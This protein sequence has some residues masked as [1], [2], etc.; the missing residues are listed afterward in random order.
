[1]D[2]KSKTDDQLYSFDYECRR[3]IAR[4]RALQKEI[5]AE[6]DRRMGFAPRK[7]FQWYKSRPLTV[8]ETISIA[9]FANESNHSAEEWVMKVETML[10]KRSDK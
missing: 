4:Y 6:L 5:M 10:K 7:F 3:S 9:Q 1:M 8:D 2:L